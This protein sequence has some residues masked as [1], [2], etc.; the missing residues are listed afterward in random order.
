MD[1]NIFFDG[2]LGVTG[3]FSTTEGTGDHGDFLKG[4]Y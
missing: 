2:I 1:A 3:M 4:I